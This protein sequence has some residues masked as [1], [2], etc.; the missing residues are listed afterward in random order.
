MKRRLFGTMLLLC[1]GSTTFAQLERHWNERYYFN[2]NY[3]KQSI[4]LDGGFESSSTHLTNSVMNSFISGETIGT[5]QLGKIEKWNPGESLKLITNAGLNASYR[6]ASEGTFKWTINA[7]VNE[8]LT[9]TSTNDLLGLL[10]RGNAPYEA[11]TLNLGE[12]YVQYIGKQ[13][14]GFGTECVLENSVFGGSLNLEK[15]SRN[16]SIYIHP[17]STLYTAPYGTEI[18]G[19]LDMIYTHTSTTQGYAG[20]WY[21]TGISANIYGSYQYDKLTL[22]GSLSNIGFMLFG[23]I[24]QVVVTD[25]FNVD[26]FNID[27]YKAFDQSISDPNPYNLADILSVQDSNSAGTQYLPTK[28]DARIAYQLATKW[29]ASLQFQSY[30]RYGSLSVKPTILFQPI[31]KL[32]LEGTLNILNFKTFSPGLNIAFAPTEGVQLVLKT[33]QFSN[34]INPQESHSQ[35][36]FVGANLQF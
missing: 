30:I 1:V 33:E 35:A 4:W 25:A 19:E 29:K 14:L 8:S 24:N 27:D 16:Q 32:C 26:G 5:S 23:G 18:S 10:L 34:L 17:N 3:E 7:G 31:E 2:A 22:F 20:A 21:G 11:Q 12:T 6:L 13:Y 28:L 9:M 15:I 36:L